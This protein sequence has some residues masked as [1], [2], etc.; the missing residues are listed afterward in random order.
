MTYEYVLPWLITVSLT[1]IQYDQWWSELMTTWCHDSTWCDL[2]WHSFEVTNSSRLVKNMSWCGWEPSDR[3]ALDIKDPLEI[4][5]FKLNSPVIHPFIPPNLKSSSNLKE[6][7]SG[8]SAGHF[9]K[10]FQNNHS[11]KSSAEKKGS[12]THFTSPSLHP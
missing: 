4:S 5:P 2:Q 12:V 11:V 1:A 3:I 7:L 8:S 9:P 6:R 10:N